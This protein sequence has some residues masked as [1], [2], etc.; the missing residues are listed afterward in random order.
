MKEK[1]EPRLLRFPSVLEE[2]LSLMEWINMMI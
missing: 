1:K 2:R